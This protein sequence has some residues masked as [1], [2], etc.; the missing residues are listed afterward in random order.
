M[1]EE[2]K[3]LLKE[4]LAQQKENKEVLL[5]VKK[6]FRWTSFSGAFY[7]ILIAAIAL[8]AFLYIKPYLGGFLNIYNGNVSGVNILELKKSLME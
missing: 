5:S 8:G 6:N 7:W 3:E 1:G 2:E 4:I